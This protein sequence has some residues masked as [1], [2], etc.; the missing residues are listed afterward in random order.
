MA[1][2]DIEQYPRCAGELHHHV[3]R[4]EGIVQHG[5]LLEVQDQAVLMYDAFWRTCCATRIADYERV[6]E[7]DALVA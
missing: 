4:P 1:V 5:D 3:I 2:H 6:V 7:W